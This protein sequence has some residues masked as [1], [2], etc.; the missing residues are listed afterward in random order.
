MQSLSGTTDTVEDAVTVD[1]IRRL[2][3]AVFRTGVWNTSSIMVW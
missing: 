2:L 1:E 3:K